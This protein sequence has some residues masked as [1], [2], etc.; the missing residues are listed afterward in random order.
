MF[1]IKSTVVPLQKLF[2]ENKNMK[3]ILCHKNDVRFP[4]RNSQ[5]HSLL[6]DRYMEITFCHSLST[7][8]AHFYPTLFIFKNKRGLWDHLAVYALLNLFV[9]YAVRVIST[10][11]RN[12]AQDITSITRIQKILG[13][14]LGRDTDYP[15]ICSVLQS[16]DGTVLL[17]KPLSLR[18]QSL[19]ISSNILWRVRV[20][21]DWT[22]LLTTYTS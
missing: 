21:L 1:A 14:N 13:S 15:R 4:I 18:H 17:N 11:P 9:F 12:L 22:F 20:S 5:L 2:W 3:V 7:P 8:L 16:N 10:R 19:L 6:K